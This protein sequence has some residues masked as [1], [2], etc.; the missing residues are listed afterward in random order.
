ML[1]KLARLACAAVLLYG[2]VTPSGE[3]GLNEVL[4]G[5]SG[6]RPLGETELIAGLKEALRVGAGNAV[7]STSRLDGYY[8]N[9]QIK[10]PLPEN[11]R[12]AEN[13]LRMAG[14]GDQVDAFEQSM[15]RAA[16]K[17]APEAK[18]LF[19]ETIGQMTFADA[20]RILKGRENEATL[21]F[22][23]HT[24]QPLLQRFKPMVHTA[25]SEVGA[26]RYYQT[27]HSKVRNIPMAGSM[28]LD[29]DQY[30]TQGALDGLFYMLAQEEAKIRRDPAARVTELLRR[31][32]GAK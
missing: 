20:R 11:V 28:T 13:L 22:K 23:E 14:L 26:T 30:V 29:L 17:A 9:P 6:P 15:N 1:K 4:G 21:F 25:M 5:R 8:R 32:F 12:K 16:E 24:Y 7:Q 2:C 18:A 31:V 19:V 27:L 10:I 3:G